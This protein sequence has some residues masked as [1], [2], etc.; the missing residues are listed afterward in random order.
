MDH[1][2]EVELDTANFRVDDLLAIVNANS[3]TLTELDLLGSHVGDVPIR[4]FT[5]LT[6]LEICVP[7]GEE[8][9]GL[10]LVFHHAG[11][12]ESLLLVGEMAGDVFRALQKNSS[13]LP[14]LSSFQLISYNEFDGPEECTMVCD[15]IRERFLLQRFSL[16]LCAPWSTVRMVLPIVM[17]LPKLRALGFHIED[18]GEIPIIDFLFLA[19]H[20]PSTLEA[21]QLSI[22]WGNYLTLTPLVCISLPDI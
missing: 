22:P 9:R 21:L 11:G 18:H 14:R 16:R 7:E 3:A 2:S 1:S 13:S 8:L 12:L 6:H 20:L 15:F 5:A 10:D 4:I 19:C 17:E